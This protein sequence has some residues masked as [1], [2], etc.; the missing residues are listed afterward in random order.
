MISEI[1]SRFTYH[2]IGVGGICLKD[3]EILLVKHKYGPSKGKWGIPGGFVEL[4]ESLSEAIRRE[5]FEET[6]VVIQ[7]EKLLAV[8]HLTRDRA[9]GGLISDLYVVFKV[10]YK[11]GFPKVSDELEIEDTRFFSIENSKNLDIADMSKFI[12]EELLNRNG[13]DLLSFRSQPKANNEL[14]IHSYEFYG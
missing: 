10:E 13:F 8:R 2:R 6:N 12:L 7:A 1:P 3:K 5:I 11:S 14:Q 4:G 9:S